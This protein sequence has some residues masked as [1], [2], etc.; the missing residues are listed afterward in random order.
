MDE[1]RAEY[2]L[3]A[4]LGDEIHIYTREEEGCFYVVMADAEKS[5]YVL[6]CFTGE[7]KES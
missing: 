4:K 2:R 6:T 3:A 7:R 1:L 5:P